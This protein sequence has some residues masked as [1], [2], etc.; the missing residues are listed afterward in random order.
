L[1]TESRFDS[2]SD[3][4]AAFDEDSMLEPLR[5]QLEDCDS[6]SAIVAIADIDSGWGGLARSYITA[7][8]DVLASSTSIFVTGIRAEN[9]Q[10]VLNTENGLGEGSDQAAKTRRSIQNIN[11][12]LTLASFGGGNV[13]DA[14]N[15]TF[16]PLGSNETIPAY[17]LASALSTFLGT[18]RKYK[19]LQDNTKLASHHVS[20]TDWDRTIEESNQAPILSLAHDA[21][22]SSIQTFFSSNS[23]VKVTTLRMSTQIDIGTATNFSKK[24]SS[25]NIINELPLYSW[26]DI[27][28]KKPHHTEH[29]SKITNEH[30]TLAQ[31]A[32]L[33]GIPKLSM[34]AAYGRIFDSWF[35]KQ[36]CSLGLHQ[37]ETI[38]LNMQK[39]CTDAIVKNSAFALISQG[40]DAAD[41]ARHSLHELTKVDHSVFHRYPDLNMDA[42][43]DSV[44]SIL[45][46]LDIAIEPQN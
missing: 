32:V 13:D 15:C 36:N 11:I 26:P 7:A 14:I 10:D 38:P 46:S 39:S 42:L 5:H 1:D 44:S 8:T 17:N 28:K 22:L 35:Q 2:F 25:S 37:V 12:A 29:S 34:P 40:E 9:K 30:L 20:S 3:G 19:N 23:K 21:S 24:L 31:L 16:L 43:I 18:G 27:T 45:D 6:L 4:V 33:R 41:I